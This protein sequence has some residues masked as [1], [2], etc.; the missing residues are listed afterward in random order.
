MT[1]TLTTPIAMPDTMNGMTAEEWVAQP[2]PTGRHAKRVYYTA[3]RDGYSAIDS[4]DDAPSYGDNWGDPSEWP[5]HLVGT[6]QR[7]R[8][9]ERLPALIG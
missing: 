3:E 5:R 1:Q 9:P 6:E 4:H 2:Q 7:Y 8:R